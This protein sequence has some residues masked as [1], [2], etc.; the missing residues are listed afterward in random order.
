MNYQHPL[1]AAIYDRYN[2]RKRHGDELAFYSSLAM[3]ASGRVLEIACGTGMI[4]LPLLVD[5]VDIHGF[6]ISAD[7]VSVLMDKGAR[8]G[9]VGLEPRITVQNMA[10]FRYSFSFQLIM[11]PARSFLHMTSEE[12]QIGCLKTI[13][14]HLE[15]GGTLAM[16]LVNPTL[17]TLASMNRTRSD[18]ERLAVFGHRE[19]GEPVE[20][21]L[22]GSGV[23]SFAGQLQRIRYGLRLGTESVEIPMDI[24]WVYPQELRLLLKIAG[25]EKISIYGGF[26]R[27]PLSDNSSEIVCIASR[28]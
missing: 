9:C 7:M 17:G 24:R 12:D 19:T 16:N 13:L 8:Q 5:G 14:D 28:P 22:E 25:F 18:S 6:D 21:W 3:A 4:L 1:W 11:I 10:S 26:D 23:Q 20:L 2:S 15:P 27:C